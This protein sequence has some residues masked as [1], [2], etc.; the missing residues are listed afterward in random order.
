MRDCVLLFTACYPC[1]LQR[2]K[3]FGST[4]LCA[5]SDCRGFTPQDGALRY[6][7]KLELRQTTELADSLKEQKMQLHLRLFENHRSS[8]PLDFQRC[9]RLEAKKRRVAA[10]AVIR[11]LDTLSV[12]FS[13]AKSFGVQGLPKVR[14]L[15]LLLGTR[16]CHFTFPF[17]D[18]CMTRSAGL[19]RE[20]FLSPEEQP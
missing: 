17:C 6:V 16:A 8:R 15:S 18:S 5:C 12:A 20:G 3:L 19:S 2:S 10:P 14:P 7:A 13:S 1:T 11:K 9:R 4:K